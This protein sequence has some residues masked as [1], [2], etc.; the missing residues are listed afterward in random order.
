MAFCFAFFSF[1]WSLT[2]KNQPKS[3]L[4]LFY[5]FSS[6]CYLFGGMVLSRSKDRSLITFLV[7]FISCI[8]IVTAITTIAGLCIYPQATRE[9]ARETAYDASENI[10]ELKSTYRLMNIASWSQAYGMLFVVPTSLAIWKRKK[11]LLFLVQFVL[12]LIMIVMSQITFAIILAFVTA[13]FACISTDNKAKLLI[14][15][16]CLTIVLCLCL[17]NLENILAWIIK[18]SENN[19]LNFLTEK[20]TDLKRLL[21]DKS[22]EGDARS[23]FE[24]YQVSLNTFIQ[25]PLFGISLSNVYVDEKIIGFHS[26]FFDMLGSFGILGGCII[27]VLLFGYGRF[28][29]RTDR[30]SQSL[31]INVFL[32]FIVLSILNPVLNSPQILLGA[33]AYPLLCCRMNTVQPIYF[34]QVNEG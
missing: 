1:F 32:C 11:S 10:D 28:I 19:S 31:L 16:I 25:N 27:I 29:T 20:I 15:V 9:L 21:I 8:Y 22:T 14:V 34:Y 23:R 7:Y 4:Y 24:L 3:V 5:Y 30:T 6:L 33:F 2:R 17:L 26:D 12:V 13:L 18:F